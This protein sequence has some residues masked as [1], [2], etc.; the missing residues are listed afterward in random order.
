MAASAQAA[1]SA[2]S[3]SS[4]AAAAATASSWCMFASAALYSRIVGSFERRNCSLAVASPVEEYL[5]AVDAML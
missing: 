4:A 5:L 1:S 2:S 3:S